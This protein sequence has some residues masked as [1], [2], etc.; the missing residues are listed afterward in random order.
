MYYIIKCNEKYC[1]HP[2]Y[3]D[4]TLEK[5]SAYRFT[6]KEAQD[7]LSEQGCNSCEIIEVEEPEDI[8][9]KRKEMEFIPSKRAIQI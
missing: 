7:L 8:E 1:S 5:K 4:S 3:E 2:K 9:R 6:H